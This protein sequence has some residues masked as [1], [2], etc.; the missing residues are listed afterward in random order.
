MTAADRIG[1]RAG[2]GCLHVGHH[3]DVVLHDRVFGLHSRRR[4]DP[5]TRPQ[6]TSRTERER[7]G[8][9]PRSGGILPAGKVRGA[10]RWNVLG[11]TLPRCVSAAMTCP[12][13]SARRPWNFSVMRMGWSGRRRAGSAPRRWRWLSWPRGGRPGTISTRWRWTGWLHRRSQRLRRNLLGHRRLGLAR[14]DPGSQRA[15][16]GSLAWQVNEKFLRSQMESGVP[17]IDYELLGKFASVEDVLVVDP[18]SFS[19]M[20]I[21]FLKRNADAYGYRQV[22]NSW[23]RVADGRQ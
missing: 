15:Q 5:R 16:S 13:R 9:K 21:G 14:H 20:E 12:L 10:F 7:N 22:G 2:L 6:A 18:N 1:A 11:L 8:K 3:N 19:A 4:Q 23:V 17:R